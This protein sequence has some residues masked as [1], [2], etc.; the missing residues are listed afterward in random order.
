[1]CA[2]R[3]SSRAKAWEKPSVS[4]TGIVA[5]PPDLVV[6]DPPGG[7][8]AGPP[9][10]PAADRPNDLRRVAC[11]P[12]HWYPV[13]WSRELKR[14]KTLATTYAGQPIVLVRTEAGA[15]FALEDRCAHRQVPL[16]AGVVA[17]E[18]LKC[19]YHGWS[20]DGTGRCTNIPYLGADRKPAGV[21]A[22]PAREAGG[23]IFV[24]P[25]DAALAADRPL[26]DL[27]LAGDPRY[28]TRRFGR[29]VKAHYSFMHENLMDMNHQFLHRRQMGGIRA[30]CL[31]WRAI[32]PGFEVQYTFTR[33]EGKQPLG[34]AT[35]FGSKRG[36]AV[37]DEDVM[38]I[39]TVYPYQTLNIRFGEDAPVMDLW[40]AYT[41]QDA[42]QRT[43][44]TFGLLSV[45]KPGIPGLIHA[46][47]PLLIWFTERIFK[48]DRWIV[49]REQEAWEAL[50]G[51]R[52]QE[53]FP[54][55]RALRGVL[56]DRGLAAAG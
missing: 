23:L 43:N 1:M 37:A 33:T 25:G 50:G 12:D 27:G 54:A 44:R 49:E 28:K 19:C 41:P 48:E 17:G 10:D 47:W 22:Y 46:A 2:K 20:Y 14:G 5:R 26:P 36:G 8:T 40:I 29:V 11:H 4:V 39:R 52:N 42:A 15:L 3:R 32:E 53:V 31:G 55:I 56:A 38:T 35:I 45:Q 34:E 51:D 7:P 30:R 6:S 16:H 18:V 9:A 21:R 24:F 13:A